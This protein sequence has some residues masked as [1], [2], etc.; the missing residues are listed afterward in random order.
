MAQHQMTGTGNKAAYINLGTNITSKDI[1]TVYDDWAN[2]T[3][4][5]FK[6]KTKT[7]S[8]AQSVGTDY[9]TNVYI[10]CSFTQGSVSYS[11]TT[12]ILT[13]TKPVLLNHCHGTFG[14]GSTADNDVSTNPSY[15]VLLVKTD[16]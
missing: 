16:E 5:N 1:K 10:V 2:L 3:D 7:S 11:P 9:F 6:L 12:G 13:I 4:A 15:D 8:V 14:D